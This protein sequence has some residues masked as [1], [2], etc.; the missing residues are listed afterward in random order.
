MASRIVETELLHL[1]HLALCIHFRMTCW[2]DFYCERSGVLNM[3]SY[4]VVKVA[5]EQRGSCV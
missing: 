5:L 3:V 4:T 1:M 2:D